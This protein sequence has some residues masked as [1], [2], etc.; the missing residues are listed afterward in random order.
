MHPLDY[1]ARLAADA[2]H[3]DAAERLP[4]HEGTRGPAVD[5]QVAGADAFLPQALLA[6]VEAAYLEERLSTRSN[7]GGTH[8]ATGA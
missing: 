7:A 1:P 4:L 6:V 8:C 3:Q 5:V 2:G